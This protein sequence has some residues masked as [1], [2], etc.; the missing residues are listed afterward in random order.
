MINAKMLG[1]LVAAFVAGSFVASPELRA[2][3]ANTVFSTDIVDGQVM[4]SDLANNAV[5]AAKIKD[6]EVKAAE[7][8][9]NAVGASEIAADS[10]SGSE[11]SMVTKLLFGQCSPYGADGLPALGG[12]Y[13][14]ARCNISG[15]DTDDSVIANLNGQNSFCFDAGRAYVESSNVV[16]VWIRD[17]CETNDPI[18][19]GGGN[20]LSVIVYDK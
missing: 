6:N 4:T 17:E 13:I 16:A 14:V 5:T 7:I 11:L 10:V 8:A 9:T 12:G 19:Y 1:M 15:A 18:T 20:S 3:A 2:Y